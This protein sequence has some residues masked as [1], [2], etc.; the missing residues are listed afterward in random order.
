M[1]NIF[2]ECG[3]GWNKLIDPIISYIDEYNKANNNHIEILQIKEKFGQLRIYVNF[4]SSKLKKMIEEAEDQSFHTCEY[5]GSTENVGHTLGWIKTI[6]HKC[7][8]EQVIKQNYSRKWEKNKEYYII[9]PNG[10]DEKIT[11]NKSIKGDYD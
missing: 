8:K 2:I 9:H 11:E 3:K 5:C 7:I 10:E 1:K 4:T 6:C